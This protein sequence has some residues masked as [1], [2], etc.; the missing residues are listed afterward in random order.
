MT[1]KIADYGVATNARKV[2]VR[3]PGK[4][5]SNSHGARPVHRIIMMIKWIRT[6]RLSIKKSLS[7]GAAARPPAWRVLPGGELPDD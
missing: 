7:A 1:I 6:S 5:N 3:L 4:G 2:D